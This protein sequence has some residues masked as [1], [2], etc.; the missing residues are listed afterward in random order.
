[1]YRTVEFVDDMFEAREKINIVLLAMKN[2]LF[3]VSSGKNMQKILGFVETFLCHKKQ[4]YNM[5]FFDYVISRC[6]WG[7]PGLRVK[8]E[9]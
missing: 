1:M 9:P 4:V 3:V 7:G 5:A 2:F 8:S 6:I